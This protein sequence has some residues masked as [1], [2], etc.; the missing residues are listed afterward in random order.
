MRHADAPGRGPSG[1][2]ALLVGV[3]GED[4]RERIVMTIVGVPSGRSGAAG[5][6]A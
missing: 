4:V 3:L 2:R 6:V 5:V 1:D